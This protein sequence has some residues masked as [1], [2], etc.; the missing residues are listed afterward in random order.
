MHVCVSV[1]MCVCVW[2]FHTVKDI[3]GQVMRLHT[4]DAPISK[5]NN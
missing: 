1:Y 5:K 4:H 2:T 3:L